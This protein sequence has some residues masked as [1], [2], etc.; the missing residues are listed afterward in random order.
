MKAKNV[1][2]RAMDQASFGHRRLD[3]V[4]A[5]LGA[6]QLINDGGTGL[7]SDRADLCKGLRLDLAD[8]HF[9]RCELLSQ[10]SLDCRAVGGCLRLCGLTS[11]FADHVRLG[12]RL[13][14]FLLVGLDGRIGFRLQP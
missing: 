5:G 13:C 8:A 12:A 11:R 2:S 1:A 14:Q 9:R 4:R 3:V 7:F 10:F 6:D